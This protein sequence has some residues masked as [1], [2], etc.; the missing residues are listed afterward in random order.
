M[1]KT[2]KCEKIANAAVATANQRILW[3]STRPHAQKP[4]RGKYTTGISE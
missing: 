4:V 1:L 2:K 3:A